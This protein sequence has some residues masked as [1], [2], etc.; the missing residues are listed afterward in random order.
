MQPLFGPGDALY[1]LS[2]DEDLVMWPAHG[3]RRRIAIYA[4]KWRWEVDGSARLRLDQLDVL[5]AASA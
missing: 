3:A 2:R 1:V 4:R 5:A